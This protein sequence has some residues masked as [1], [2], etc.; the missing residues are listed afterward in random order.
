MNPDSLV[1][2]DMTPVDYEDFLDL[3]RICAE[4]S[5]QFPDL[6]DLTADFRFYCDLFESNRR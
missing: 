2:I 6:A 3:L 1:T 4:A 5:S